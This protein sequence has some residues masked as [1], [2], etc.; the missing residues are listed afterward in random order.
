M[1]R[2]MYVQHK[3]LDYYDVN[4]MIF[5]LHRPAGLWSERVSHGQQDFHLHQYPGAAV[6]GNIRPSQRHAQELATES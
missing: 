4:I 5:F 3:E 6:H 1:I 2:F